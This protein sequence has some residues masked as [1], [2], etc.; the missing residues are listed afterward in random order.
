MDWLED[1]FHLTE[2]T[3]VTR[4]PVTLATK[5]MLVLLDQSFACCGLAWGKVWRITNL[6]FRGRTE[7]L[8]DGEEGEASLFTV[9][10]RSPCSDFTLP[11][12]FLV[13][14]S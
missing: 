3:L 7:T 13:F 10:S 6:K 1:S 2:Q 5:D 12:R 8:W 11:R 4:L 14:G 9:R